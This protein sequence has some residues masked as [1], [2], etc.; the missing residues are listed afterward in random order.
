MSNRFD[1]M[2]ELTNIRDQVNRVLE[3]TFSSSAITVSFDLYE[4]ESHVVMVSSPLLGLDVDSLDISIEDNHL[5]V[6]GQTHPPTDIADDQ[7]IRRERKFGAV[8]RRIQ[9]PSSVKAEETR[10]EYKEHI[11][12]IMLPKLEQQGPKVVKVTPI[13]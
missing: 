10:A 1:P 11:L 12:T 3:D 2:K 4:T 7:Y 8:S 13:Q 5:L 9:I 6:E